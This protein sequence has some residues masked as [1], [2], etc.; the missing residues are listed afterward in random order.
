MATFAPAGRRDATPRG[1]GPWHARGVSGADETRA[2]DEADA[3]TPVP[4]ALV[5]G[6]DATTVAFAT[7]GWAG[8]T[9]V[10]GVA[11]GA[12]DPPTLLGEPDHTVPDEAPR[13]FS[14]RVGPGVVYRT[15]EGAYVT[16]LASGGIGRAREPVL[17]LSPARAVALAPGRRGTRVVAWDGRRVFALGIDERGIPS[18]ERSLWLE[19]AGRTA[20]LAAARVGTGTVAAI[21]FDDEPALHVLAEEGGRARAVRHD[22]GAPVAALAMVGAGNRA[23]VA[24]VL[25]GGERVAVAQLDA[26]G[27]FVERPA[28]R[29]EGR[30]T[31]YDAPVVLFVEDGFAL[32]VRDPGQRTAQLFRFEGRPAP[33]LTLDRVDAPP[34][35]AWHEKRLWLATATHAPGED[36]ISA[37]V[38][39]ASLDK[40]GAAVVT[41]LRIE[42][43]AA[44]RQRRAEGR[45][46]RVL[47]DA[48]GELSTT[49][50]RGTLEA[51]GRATASSAARLDE[52][53]LALSLGSVRTSIEI[54]DAGARATVVV[55]VR[56]P[57]AGTDPVPLGSLERLARWVR[58]RLSRKAWEA[59]LAETAWID[60]LADAIGGTGRAAPT[61]TGLVLLVSVDTL[62]SGE[63]LARWIRRIQ[64]DVRERLGR[65]APRGAPETSARGGA[66][67]D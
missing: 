32:V 13:L 40:R 33:L 19:R 5:P 38:R 46:L 42:P 64:E 36:A 8:L 6:R 52:D 21:A 9:R 66:D 7:T 30:G 41:P 63:A 49:S 50:Y 35:A 45:A 16:T 14:T 11:S 47:R 25:D 56:E 61:K 17:L 55:V 12:L 48:A 39:R 18:G 28:T 1:P 27:R 34:A 23:G 62:P 4:L 10:H 20:Q 37:L 2:D 51:G 31:R 15:P 65:P 29:I 3:R 22:L 67:R 26:F 53:A 43:P 44:L 54:E 59:A 58:V 60:A 24:L 57:D